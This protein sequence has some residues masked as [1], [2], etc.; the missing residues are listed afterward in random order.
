MD[1][2]QE[3]GLV[4][5]AREFNYREGGDAE[6]IY[7]FETASSSYY[8]ELSKWYDEA[9]EE[10][11]DKELGS[12]RAE[13]ERE[14]LESEYLDRFL[15]G[16]AN[17]SEDEKHWRSQ[18]SEFLTDRLHNL[19][20]SRYLAQEPV[21]SENETTWRNENAEILHNELEF[22]KTVESCL[23]SATWQKAG[24]S[25]FAHG[26]NRIRRGKIRAYIESYLLAHGRVPTGEH[27]AEGVKVTFPS[28]D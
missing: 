18:N 22:V 23:Y 28:A 4:G 20:R 12:T 6:E 24:G 1:N 27:I 5:G 7:D 17:K 11:L 8:P 3:D 15:E 10:W 25:Q 21:E 13:R 9:N 26:V 2:A 19:Y 16:G 14:Q